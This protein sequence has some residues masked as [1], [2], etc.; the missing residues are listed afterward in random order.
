MFFIMK[1]TED[2]IVSPSDLSKD[3]KKIVRVKLLEK[4]TGTCNSRYGYYIKVIKIGDI[5]N[6]LIMEGTGD[7]IF[8][9]KYKV[10]L[11]R[12][13]V[14]EICDGVIDSVFDVGGFL[15][16][17]G[18]MKVHIAKVDIPERFVLDKKNLC[19]VDEKEN[20]EL[21]KG[22]K[23]RFRFKEDQFFNNEFKPTGT[24][25]ANYLGYIQDNS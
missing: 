17:V 3:L 20:I 25:R 8:K 5:T 19:Y 12:P 7:I 24:I 23:V 10:V 14:G 1:F 9:I 21:R 11:M 13:F 16:S 2:V 22:T 4:V 18:P 15:V 6:G